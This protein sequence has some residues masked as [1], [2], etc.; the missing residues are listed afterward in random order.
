[1][2]DLILSS[3]M[4]AFLAETTDEDQKSTILSG[5][6]ALPV[7]GGTME[8]GAAIN[9]A[10]GSRLREGLTDAGNGGANGVALV[11]SLDYEFKWEAGRLYVM[12]QDG[13]TIRVEQYGFNNIPSTAD[14]ETKGY[15]VGS[16]RILD[17]GSTYVCTDSTEEA[18]V[19]VLSGGSEVFVLGDITGATTLNR[20][21]GAKQNAAATG[22]VTL[23]VSNGSDW[24]TLDLWITASGA[25]RTLSLNAAVKTPS[26]SGIT[27]PVTI[28][29]DKGAR[30]KFEKHGSTWVLVS[31]VK[32][33]AL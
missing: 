6:G 22:N 13:F 27:F 33:F 30:V 32:S 7:A 3:A 10:N 1:M 5:I 25:A 26:D 28:D 15:V 29:S 31:L 11:C 24:D 14:D 18:A 20:T 4:D 21:S 9:F 17:D 12:E 2:S 19:W 8:S 16:R 23:N